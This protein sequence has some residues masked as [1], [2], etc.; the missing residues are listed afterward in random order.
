MTGC[1]D[2][3]F[4]NGDLDFLGTPY[5]PEW[6]TGTTPAIHPSSFVES[7]PTSNGQQYPEF[8]MQTD[9]ALSEYECGGGY[10]ANASSSA[11]GCTVPP[12]GPGGFYPYWSQVPGNGGCSLEFGNVSS[13]LGVS[14]FGK[15]AQYG[16]DQF[17]LYGHPQFIGATHVNPCTFSF[18]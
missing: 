11:A 9:I 14:T 18:G 2:N 10:Y 4:Q 13:G 8:Y 12:Q 15:D 17:A 16:T 7:F 3:L 6:P 1:Q 5:Y